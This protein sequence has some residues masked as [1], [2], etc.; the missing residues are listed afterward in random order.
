MNKLIVLVGL[1]LSGKSEVADQLKK[2]CG[3]IT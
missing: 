3:I 1:P 2:D